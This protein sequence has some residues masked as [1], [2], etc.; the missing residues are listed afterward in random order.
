MTHL[1][2]TFLTLLLCAFLAA[3]GGSESPTAPDAG[4]GDT[5]G[6]TGGSTR[7]I[8]T[9]PAFGADIVEIFTRRG[10]ASGSCHGGGAGGLTLSS[11][12]ATSHGNLVGVA[13]P[14]T[15]EIRVIAN[16]ATNSY[17]VKKLEGTA[18]AGSRMP[19]GGSALDNT[20][21]TNIKNWINTGA[22]NN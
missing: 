18:S 22:P 9:N 7:T 5:G 20:D 21:L 8:K 2:P 13:S 11:N 12:A 17:L 15:G 14:T 19:I 10:C 4:G 1:R 3:C 6:N 16:D